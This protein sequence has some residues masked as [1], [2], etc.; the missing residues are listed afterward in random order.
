LV[1]TAIFSPVAAGLG[2]GL[3]DGLEVALEVVPPQL[4]ASSAVKAKALA[5]M[6][7]DFMHSDTASGY[8]C[9]YSGVT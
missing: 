7:L 6:S 4:A 1:A 9:A 8:E 2:D 3:G 5:A